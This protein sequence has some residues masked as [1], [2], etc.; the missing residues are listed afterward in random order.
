MIFIGYLFGTGVSVY[1]CRLQNKTTDFA[2]FDYFYFRFLCNL[3]ADITKHY[4]LF[5]LATEPS[6][7]P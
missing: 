4:P 5:I 1:F 7:T 3:K 2:L 6:S